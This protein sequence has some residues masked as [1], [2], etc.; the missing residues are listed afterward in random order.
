M[1]QEE[2]IEALEKRVAELEARILPPLDK[3]TYR[4]ALFALENGNPKPL[5]QPLS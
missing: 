4:E 1:T 5:E 2:K 3:K